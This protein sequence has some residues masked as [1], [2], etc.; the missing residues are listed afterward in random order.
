MKQFYQG[1]TVSLYFEHRDSGA[2]ADRTTS[3]YIA[4]KDSSDQV[5][6]AATTTL[7]KI[8]GTTGK[9][10][11]PY[12]IDDVATTG[13]YTAQAIFTN[14]TDVNKAGTIV[15]EVLEKVG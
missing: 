12:A 1:E 15:F 10:L 4:V 2:L 6:V 7:S 8:T 5:V 9:Y 13:V 14:G 11:Y 3:S